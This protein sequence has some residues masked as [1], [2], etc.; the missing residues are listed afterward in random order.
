[1]QTLVSI[2][3]FLA[4]LGAAA[5]AAR[6]I[7]RVQ[8][9]AWLGGAFLI[10]LFLAQLVQV[11]I[12]W[13]GLAL[14]A[15]AGWRLARGSSAE[16]GLA[17][18]GITAALGA[19]LYAE[20]GLSIWIAAILCLAVAGGAALLAGNAKFASVA[21]RDSVLL[22]VAWIAPVI[23]AAPGVLAGWGSAQAL[24]QD[25][26]APVIDF[27]LWAWLAPVAAL[28]AGGLRGGWVKK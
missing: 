21:V 11:Q 14:S 6:P 13:V 1:M 19:A 20:S 16:E 2:M 23:A 12:E 24:N 9:L 17:L 10:A 18:A 22:L 28:L 26:A 7:E 3:L 15:M 4:L 5:H 27:P 8:S 25:V